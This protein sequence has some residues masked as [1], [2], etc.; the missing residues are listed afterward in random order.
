MRSRFVAAAALATCM[1]A[2]GVPTANAWQDEDSSDPVV[3]TTTLE[4]T[5]EAEPGD[6]PQGS[7]IEV[8]LALN[9]AAAAPG[10]PVIATAA[11]DG[12]DE[13]AL[14]S[15]VLQPV[16]LTANPSGHQP[17]ALSGSTTV[18][19]DAQPGDYQVSAACDAGPVS[20]TMTVLPAAGDTE[21]TSEDDQVD[22]VPAGA[23]ET[24][25]GPESALPGLLLTA[26]GLGG[27]AGVGGVAVRR[28]LQR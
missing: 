13:A 18:R 5:G 24:G 3:T 16:V 1:M 4:P 17:W 26:A 21:D 22:R 9:P 15:S 8:T 19:Q 11:C 25:G 20:T 6:Q 10:Q 7:P 14:T 28:V 12:P 27:I 2:L 23:P